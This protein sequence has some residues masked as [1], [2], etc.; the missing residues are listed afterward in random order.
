MVAR[1]AKRVE[2]GETSTGGEKEAQ[3]EVAGAKRV[4]MQ[5]VEVGVLSTV[6]ETGAVEVAAEA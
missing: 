3:E 1:G 5:V 6:G 2:V 4:E